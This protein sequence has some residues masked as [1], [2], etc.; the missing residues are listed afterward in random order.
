MPCVVCC[1]GELGY[2][3]QVSICTSAV[4]G[5]EAICQIGYAIDSHRILCSACS[6]IAR[7]AFKMVKAPE[8]KGFV[9]A[10][11]NPRKNGKRFLKN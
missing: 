10:S 9:C 8:E 2:A 4:V 1:D 6:K 11:A 7:G 5:S 3:F